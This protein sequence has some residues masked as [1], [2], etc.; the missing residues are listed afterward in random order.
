MQINASS[1]QPLEQ[2][3][4]VRL[5]VEKPVEP[6]EPKVK[7]EPLENPVE[8]TEQS[9]NFE[10]LKTVLAENNITLKF[11]QDAETKALVVKLVDSQTGE[12]IRQMPTEISLKLAAD[13]VKMQGQ[14]VDQK[15]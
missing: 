1:I 12:A 2:T 9:E 14:F 4:V 15:Q 11:S 6:K 10:K 3:P 8:K 13:F 7:I 5:Q